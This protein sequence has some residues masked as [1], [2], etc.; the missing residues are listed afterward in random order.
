MSRV[1]IRPSWALIF[2][3]KVLSAW[4]SYS[5]HP[6]PTCLAYKL[7][8][9]SA[10]YRTPLNIWNLILVQDL[11][12]EVF[13]GGFQSPFGSLFYVGALSNITHQ[14]QRIFSHRHRC[15]FQVR[16]CDP[17]DSQEVRHVGVFI[18]D[19]FGI[20]FG[21]QPIK[22]ALARHSGVQ[23]PVIFPPW[24]SRGHFGLPVPTYG[25]TWVVLWLLFCRSA[26]STFPVTWSTLKGP[27]PGVPSR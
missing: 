5:V 18:L 21:F 7:Q 4:Q 3:V 24:G 9:I 16:S 26:P 6:I 1:G 11:R 27:F 2:L 22:S 10:H 25:S 17:I 23:V 15:L 19:R 13:S 8:I 12:H 20:P 14:S